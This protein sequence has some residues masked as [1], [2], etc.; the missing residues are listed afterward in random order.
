MKK[1]K[2]KKLIQKIIISLVLIASCQFIMPNH[3]KAGWLAGELT[4]NI[5]QFFASIGDVFTGMMNSFMLGG[6]SVLGSSMLSQEEAEECWIRQDKEKNSIDKE[7]APNFKAAV[8]EEIKTV[9][10]NPNGIKIVDKSG[11]TGILINEKYFDHAWIT[12][13]AAYEYPNMVYSPENIFA[14]NI[15]AFDIN[16]INP[17]LY[18]SG[19]ES[20]AVSLQPTIASWYKTFRNIAAVGLLSVLLYLG[21]RIVI[22]SVNEK[23]KYKEALKDWL[24]A[25]CLLFVMQFIIVAIL[26]ITDKFNDIFGQETNNILVCIVN[27]EEPNDGTASNNYVFRSNF[28]GVARMLIQTEGENWQNIVAYTI[29]YFALIIY[30]IMFTFQYFKRVLYMAFYTMISPLVAMSYPL[31]KAGDTKAQAFNTW[32]KEVVMTALTQPIHLLLYT[33]LVSSAMELTLKNPIYGLV[34]IGFL[35]PA[36][37][38]VK[39]L[40][41][42]Q[43]QADQGMGSFAGGAMTMGLLNKLTHKPPLPKGGKGEN[44][45]GSGSEGGSSSSDEGSS[46]PNFA[47]V[48]N[49]GSGNPPLNPGDNRD[50]G[51]PD[52][53]EDPNVNPNPTQPNGSNQGFPNNTNTQP[54][55]GQNGYDEDDGQNPD[56]Y[57]NPTGAN[58]PRGNEQGSNPSG[59]NPQGGN[60]SGGNPPKNNRSG[61]KKSGK[62]KDDSEFKRKVRRAKPYAGKVLKS[63]GKGALK[64][65]LKGLTRATAIGG[66]ALIGTAAGLV[67]GD[68]SNVFKYA[69]AGAVAGN[70]IGK[71]LNE[72]VSK[73]ATYLK[74]NVPNAINKARIVGTEINDGYLAADNKRKEIEQAKADRE[75]MKSK[76]QR[77]RYKKIAAK[78]EKQTG[79]QYSIDELMNVASDY[80]KNKVT[81][82][83]T[84]EKGLIL[85]AQKGDIG[86][87]SHENIMAVSM[88][89]Q[90]YDKSYLYDDKKNK[91]LRK[92]VGASV[93]DA[94]TENVM[95]IFRELHENTSNRPRSK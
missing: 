92:E 88:L 80:R 93:G 20:I 25:M 29:I 90:Q 31:D 94:E 55:G 66:G 11:Y 17:S 12:N 41:G 34:C 6:S 46:T 44:G 84:I 18:S 32:F 2:N 83:N 30:T 58:P 63:A 37:K 69:G 50:P 64:G 85:E 47:S 77:E 71:N 61:S 65:T 5:C 86:G 76:Q 89:A 36:E 21:I 35:I 13:E 38:F 7:L 57:N 42:I 82:N 75:F 67:T 10:D 16:F 14:N 33:M 9:A 68:M 22:G 40:F 59:S 70:A 53:E 52:P 60:P 91:A 26:T 19:G 87:A 28:M 72:T 56:N 43:P 3:A 62:S 79:K 23:A 1:T 95:N 49:G 15:P 74:D 27:Q 48:Y 24:F 8:K 45:G 78:I 4:E 73:G 39:S 54:L 51:A 81:D